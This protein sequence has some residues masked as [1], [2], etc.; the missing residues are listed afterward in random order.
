[1]TPQHAWQTRLTAH[2]RPVPIAENLTSVT[3]MIGPLSDPQP[4]DKKCHSHT[5]HLERHTWA[6]ENRRETRRPGRSLHAGCV[7]AGPL[8]SPRGTLSGTFQEARPMLPAGHNA[9]GVGPRSRGDGRGWPRTHQ[10]PRAVGSSEVALY[11]GVEHLD[12]VL[13]EKALMEMLVVLHQSQ[14][15]LQQL[16]VGLHVHHVILVE[17]RERRRVKPRPGRQTG[18][19]ARAAPLQ[20]AARSA[21][22]AGSRHSHHTTLTPFHNELVNPSAAVKRQAFS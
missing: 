9:Q 14:P 16:V 19:V 21:R 13:R 4:V 20:G 17:L 8:R 5:G 6:T 11:V 3:E 7:Q 1:M 15:G 18:S 22:G 12:R 10:V 2:T